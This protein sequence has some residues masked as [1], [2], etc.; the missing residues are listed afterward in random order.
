MNE[1][2][3]TLRGHVGGDVSV[4]QAGDATVS[5]FRVAVTPRRFNARTE[6]WADADTQWY[7]VNA[8]RALGENVAASI[9]RGDAVVVHG[10]LN[11]ETWTN[12]AGVQVTS[13]DVD[14]YTVGHDLNRGTSAFTRAP[15]A[16]TLSV[17]T[18]DPVAEAV[19]DDD[20]ERTAA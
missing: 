7:T 20:Q 4:R 15:R 14:A 9:N 5:S 17:P 10:R 8:W 13:F 18:A 6:E 12:K 2:T 16:E 3:V 19:G 1:T 11:A